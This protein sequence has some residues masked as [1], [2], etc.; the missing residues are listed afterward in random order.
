LGFD[1]KARPDICGRR[2][3]L[4]GGKRFQT[5]GR[6]RPEVRGP[7][8]PYPAGQGVEM[9]ATGEKRRRSSADRA[10]PQKYCTL[11]K[12]NG[13]A[14]STGRSRYFGTPPPARRTVRRGTWRARPW[15]RLAL[16]PL[17]I[18]WMRWIERIAID[19]NVGPIALVFEA[20]LQPVM[21]WLT[22]RAQRAEAKGVVVAHM[23]RMMIS[24][25]RW[26]CSPLL[27]TV[28]A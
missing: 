13:P 20:R 17:S 9:A 15:Q 10:Q 24:D 4:H 19:A 6:R 8:R 23:R 26:R 12:G 14:P 27:S 2:T 16:P 22:E 18:P 1:P 5:W 25:R 7:K 28:D 21:A 3:S 11:A